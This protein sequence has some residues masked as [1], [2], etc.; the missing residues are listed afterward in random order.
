MNESCQAIFVAYVNESIQIFL[1]DL[2]TK[3]TLKI[4]KFNQ[5]TAFQLLG[6]CKT[7]VGI[8]NVLKVSYPILLS[9]SLENLFSSILSF[10]V[11]LN[12]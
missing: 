7:R 5:V 10:T 12:E 4:Q 11:V 8:M 6:L 9:Y 1:T 3:G 2:L